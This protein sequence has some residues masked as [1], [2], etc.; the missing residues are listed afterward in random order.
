MTSG[1][2]LGVLI[3]GAGWVS[4]QHIKAFQANPYTEVVAISSRRMESCRRRAEEAGLEGVALYT[5]Y[6]GALKH[7]GVDIVS[8]CTP[9]HLHPENAIAAAEAGKHMVIEKPVAN[10]LQEMREMLDAVKKAGVKTVVSFVLRWNPLFKTLKKLIADDFFGNVYYV[11]ADYQS[12]IASW[13]SG[14]DWARRKETGVSAFLVAGC[15]AIDAVRWFAGRGEYEAANP[16]EVFAYS[17]GWRRGS[18]IEYDYISGVWRKGAPPLEYD[19]LEVALI[20][21]DNGV[22]GKVSTNFD[23]IMPYTFPIEIFGD[24]G[25]AKDNRIWSHK[26]PEQKGWVEIPT[27]MPDTADVTHHPFQGEIDHFVDCILNGV[28]SHCNLE[29]AIRT[30]EIAFAALRCY[31]TGKPV[32]LPLL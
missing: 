10:S 2:K 9:Q 22:L 29:D 12:N 30:H 21:F 11:E 32:K 3:H 17:G 6:E 25:T 15:H 14:Y 7:D 13:W 19:G 16:V 27:V 24:K 18:D 23:C 1:R 8:I 31:E 26:Y 20:K 28:E 4:T 5:D